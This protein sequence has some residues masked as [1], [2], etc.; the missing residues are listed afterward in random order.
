MIEYRCPGVTSYGRG[1]TERTVHMSGCCAAFA[2]SNPER[3]AKI[4]LRYP[5]DP[6]PLIGAPPDDEPISVGELT[7]V[8]RLLQLADDEGVPAPV[9]HVQYVLVEHDYPQEQLDALL[10][11]G[12]GYGLVAHCIRLPA[13]PGRTRT[14][15]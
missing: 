8:V 14:E 7:E 9:S 2:L 1:L 4:G 3:R 15:G 12:A 5:A 6:E 11:L 10:D 13:V